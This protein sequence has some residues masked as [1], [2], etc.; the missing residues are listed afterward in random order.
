M[1]DDKKRLERTM[2]ARN[3]REKMVNNLRA[4]GGG[5]EPLID[6]DKQADVQTMQN[7]GGFD[8]SDLM[9]KPEMAQQSTRDQAEKVSEPYREANIVAAE[10]TNPMNAES[11]NPG[12]TFLMNYLQGPIPSIKN[13]ESM[14]VPRQ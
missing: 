1:E 9:A 8:A 2:A 6:R 11:Q 4:R 12:E 13:Y 10:K 14:L 7:I 5:I 3:F